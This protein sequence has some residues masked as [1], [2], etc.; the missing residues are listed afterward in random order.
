MER[1]IQER[2]KDRDVLIRGIHSRSNSSAERSS[3][4]SHADSISS[5]GSTKRRDFEDDSYSFSDISDMQEADKY[6][7]PL[8]PVSNYSRYRVR[9]ILL[10][11]TVLGLVFVAYYDLSTAH[12][13]TSR[14]ITSSVSNTKRDHHEPYFSNLYKNK[15]AGPGAFPLSL[16]SALPSDLCCICDCH[17]SPAF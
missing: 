17:A 1:T 2:L 5:P 10:A 14:R 13:H 9:R 12:T 6:L 15:E 11:T 7:Q 4:E 3:N 16:Q 8:L